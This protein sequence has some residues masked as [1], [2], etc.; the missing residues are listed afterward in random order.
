MVFLHFNIDYCISIYY[1]MHVYCFKSYFVYLKIF[2][3]NCE[4][5]DCCECKIKFLKTEFEL[6]Y[7][8]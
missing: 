1:S 2:I 3:L 4:Q 8:R 5:G 6:L 7:A